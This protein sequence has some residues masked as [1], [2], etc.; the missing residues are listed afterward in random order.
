MQGQVMKNLLTIG[1][2]LC[3]TVAVSAQSLPE[4][5]AFIIHGGLI[6]PSDF[7]VVGKNANGDVVQ[8]KVGDS[9][10]GHVRAI[11]WYVTDKEKCIVQQETEEIL[12]VYGHDQTRTWFEEIGWDGIIIQ[13]YLNNIV[14]ENTTIYNQGLTLAGEDYLSCKWSRVDG[15]IVGQAVGCT[16]SACP[17]RGG[18]LHGG[19]LHTDKPDCSKQ[20]TLSIHQYQYAER[21]T[22]ALKYLYKNYCTAATRRSAF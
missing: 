14:L 7:K 22:N 3:G 10:G 18:V 12:P 15:K 20:I 5:A 8:E 17:A 16:G 9:I 1:I 6:D 2:L 21:V 4:T 11:K 19:V 13:Y